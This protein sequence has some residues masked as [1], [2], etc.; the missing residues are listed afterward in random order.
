M[1]RRKRNCITL[2]L[3]AIQ[4]RMCCCKEHL[5]VVIILSCFGVSN[6][7]SGNAVLQ[8]LVEIVNM[9]IIRQSLCILQN[10]N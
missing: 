4:V 8:D 3:C 10:S 1:I 2:Q 5:V 7:L 6:P 9:K